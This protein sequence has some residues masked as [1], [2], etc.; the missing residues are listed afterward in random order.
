MIRQDEGSKRLAGKASEVAKALGSDLAYALGVGCN[1]GAE[2][3][4]LAFIEG[5]LGLTSR[6][7][8]QAGLAECIFG[9]L[10]DPKTPYGAVGVPSNTPAAAYATIQ[11]YGGSVEAQPGK[12]LAIPISPEAKKYTS[13][14]DMQFLE[15]MTRRG[16]PPLLVRK[17]LKATKG[18][19]AIEVHWVL[20]QR[21]I[22]PQTLWLSRGAKLAEPAIAAAMKSAIN[23]RTSGRLN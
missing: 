20:V 2:E 7:G 17:R 19:T 21:V 18:L 22:I 9:W 4:R 1:V 13:P 16:K 15:I 5:K 6:H 14:R 23:E 8:G 3:I 12:A 11:H 10:I